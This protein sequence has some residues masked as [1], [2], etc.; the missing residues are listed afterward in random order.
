[1]T[2]DKI[3]IEI[4]RRKRKWQTKRH[5]C[6]SKASNRDMYTLHDES[7]G[8]SMSTHVCMLFNERERTITTRQPT[9]SP[10]R[11]DSLSGLSSRMISMIVYAWIHQR[12]VLVYSSRQSWHSRTRELHR[13]TND[14]T[15]QSFCNY[16]TASFHYH[17]NQTTNNWNKSNIMYAHV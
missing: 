13:S 8:Q 6:F 12:V 11:D 2:F 14:L 1:M 15:I 9:D 4:E 16:F 17:E 7:N 3:R 5:S 10:T